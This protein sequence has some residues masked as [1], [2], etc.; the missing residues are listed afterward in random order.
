MFR[1]LARN[2]LRLIVLSSLFALP[3]S[4]QFEI[5]PDHFNARDKKSAPKVAQKITDSSTKAAQLATVPAASAVSRS[6]ETAA[7]RDPHKGAQGASHRTQRVS[8][9]NLSGNQVAATR[10]TRSDKGRGVAATP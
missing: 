10:G 3:G 5:A 9:R 4:A 6:A 8:K 7:I 1:F 2:V